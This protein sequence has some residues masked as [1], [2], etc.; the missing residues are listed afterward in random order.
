MADAIR[1]QVLDNAKGLVCSER[2]A[3]Y[4]EPIDNFRRWADALN[5]YGYQGPGGRV[6]LPHDIAVIMTTGK[7]SRAVQTPDN[8]EHWTDGAGYLAN[9][10]ECVTL[11]G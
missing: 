8:P 4:G 9:G 7:L 11:E 6:L 5:A 1:A 3:Q 10:Y 2:N